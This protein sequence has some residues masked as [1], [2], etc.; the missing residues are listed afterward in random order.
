MGPGQHSPCL[1]SAMSY[2]TALGSHGGARDTAGSNEAKGRH[3]GEAMSD[4]PQNATGSSVPA[5]RN[6]FIPPL[7]PPCSPMALAHPCTG[8]DAG[9][10]WDRPWC[11]EARPR[12]G[13]KATALRMLCHHRGRGQR[14]VPSLAAPSLK[15][16]TSHMCQEDVG[17]QACPGTSGGG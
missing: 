15:G 9:H 13:M 5:R 11:R 12:G 16:P 7:M 17:D 14:D 8:G 10:P 2:P 4:A 1:C 3:R 6:C